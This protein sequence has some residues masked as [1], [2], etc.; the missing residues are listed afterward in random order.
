MRLRSITLSWFRGAAASATLPLD[1][2]SAVVF[3]TNGAGKSSFVDAVEA[4][5]CGGKVRH[6]SHMY[7]GRHQEKGL[8]NTARPEGAASTVELLLEDGSRTVSR[9][10]T[11][12]PAL[13][14]EG[15]SNPAEWDYGRT[16]LRQEEL[17]DFIRSTKGEKYSAVLP[18][19]GLSNLEAAAENLHKLAAVIRKKSELQEMRAQVALARER[20][21]EAFGEKTND[22]LLAR[23]E[24]LRLTYA[25]TTPAEPRPKAVDA[26]LAAIEARIASLDADNRRAAAIGEFA[27]SDLALRLATARQLGAEIADVSEPFIKERLEVLAAAGTYAEAACEEPGSLPC[28]ACGQEI[29]NAEFRAHVAQERERLSAAETLYA[30][31]RAAVGDVC[32]EAT[33][34][35]QLLDRPDLRTWRGGLDA[36]LSDKAR[37][38]SALP[39]ADLR[40]V[41]GAGELLAIEQHAEP[42]I[43]RA[44]EDAKFTPPPV[45]TLVDHQT[46]A[47][48]LRGSLAAS[49]IKARIARVDG[50]IALT[51]ALE[52]GVRD[53]IKQR[54]RSV[55]ETITEDIQRY[56]KVL[57]PADV[58][59]DLRLQ[60]PD[61]GEKAI[62]VCLRF[63]G[64]EQESPCLTLS[65]GQRNALGLCI[66]LAM[67]N[68]AADTDRPILLDDV[69]ISF[70]RE[71]RSQVAKL[72]EQEFASRQVV[73]LTH[74]REWYF[75]LQRML[76][77]GKWR[78]FH[79]KR[80]A[81][82]ETGITFTDHA[83]DFDAAR[84]LV[85]SNPTE[86]LRTTRGLMD[87]ALSETA[88][89]LKVPLPHVRGETNDHR[90]AGEFLIAFERVI[91]KCLEKKQGETYAADPDAHPAIMRVKPELSVWANRAV[92]TFDGT[93]FEAEELINASE[94][95]LAKFVCD[96]CRHPVGV[97]TAAGRK[98]ECRCGTL[99]W[100]PG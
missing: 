35:R 65:E 98:L 48:A 57:Q 18:L 17:S 33:R 96:D 7:S 58:I 94:A 54:A 88:E 41:C 84:A 69:V 74:D 6:L 76:A 59:T 95:L 89:R 39:V 63:H 86:A 62:E 68:R 87:L 2:K 53:E 4:T 43:A 15:A 50:L 71:H 13:V 27:A 91:G 5:L 8:L 97:F 31:Y 85:H 22:E 34:L 12:A 99:R 77:A 26:V 25:P 73:I 9:W 16:A 66:F 23:L 64:R 83:L 42:L 19:L 37:F 100:R 80:Y 51:E 21:A 60:V 1:G 56:W 30:R 93:P 47:R 61:D 78:Y 24:E 79:L 75:E 36:D 29:D 20:R 32:D 28:P 55:F 67:A 49:L 40:N 44:V 70:D 46:Q 45:Q 11:G 3:G 90:T 72:L 10:T 14:A 52:S 82:P 92:H 81:D 38:I